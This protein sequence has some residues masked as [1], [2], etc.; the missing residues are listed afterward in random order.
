VNDQGYRVVYRE[1]RE[2]LEHRYLFEQLLGRPL[3][4]T[5]QVHHCNKVRTDN[6]TDGPPDANYR[7]GNLE[8]WTT[9]QPSG[10]RVED[11]VA[12]AVELL[13]LYAPELL[14]RKPTQ[15]RLA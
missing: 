7:T 10:A 5:E 4:E 14:A 12:Y 3:L 9:S 6:R 8:L 1:G 15:L 11:M 2:F 13:E